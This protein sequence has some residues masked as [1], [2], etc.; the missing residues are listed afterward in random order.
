MTTDQSPYS[1]HAW[2]WTLQTT[3]L[4]PTHALAPLAAKFGQTVID[5]TH[6]TVPAIKEANAIISAC[7]DRSLLLFYLLICAKIAAPCRAKLMEHNPDPQHQAIIKALLNKF[8]DRVGILFNGNTQ[9]QK[10][11]RVYNVHGLIREL[12]VWMA[13][14]GY[15][16][17]S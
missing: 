15:K 8:G 14:Q 4:V 17:R 7:S 10:E 13:M 1:I 5:R 3:E 9:R 12:Q 2:F 6:T 16:K 11:T